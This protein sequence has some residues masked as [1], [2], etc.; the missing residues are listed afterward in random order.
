[1]FEE[2]NLLLLDTQSADVEEIFSIKGLAMPMRFKDTLCQQSGY[3]YAMA[4]W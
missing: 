1:M 2:K 3:D 4:G